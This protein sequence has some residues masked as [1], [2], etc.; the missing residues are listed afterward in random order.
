MSDEQTKTA[1]EFRDDCRGLFDAFPDTAPDVVTEEEWG[2]YGEARL[3]FRLHGSRWSCAAIFENRSI[4]GFVNDDAFR[5]LLPRFVS[6][7]LR[8]NGVDGDILDYVLFALRD[9]TGKFASVFSRAQRAAL[10]PPLQFLHDRVMV[11]CFPS[12]RTACDIARIVRKLQASETG[13]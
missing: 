5:F 10:I 3:A 8:E 11:E 13:P 2:D 12:D 4:I 1:N 7:A 9:K 6:C